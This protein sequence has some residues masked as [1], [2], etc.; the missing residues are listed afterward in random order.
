MDVVVD[1][2]GTLA[3]CSHRLHHIKG[4]GRKNWDAFFAG[5]HL[6]QPNPVIVALVKAL[7]KEH[8]LIFCSGRP[9]RMRRAT[10]EWLQMYLGL[11]PQPLYM[12]SDNDRRV[13]DI[14]KREL[15]AR[16]RADQ[17]SP[18]LAIDDRRGSSTCGVPKGWSAPKWPREIF[19]LA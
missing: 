14:V 4:R 1:L 5:C 10:T 16:M 18:A 7:Q 3:D 15:L 6:D 2:D 17:F 8:R 9:E 12:R 19:R 13:D 11:T